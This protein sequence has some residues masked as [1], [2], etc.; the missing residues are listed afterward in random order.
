MPEHLPP[1]LSA[2]W[3]TAIMM[4]RVSAAAVLALAL[5]GCGEPGPTTQQATVSGAVTIDGKPVAM[6]STITFF[7]DSEGANAGGV[8]D[9]IGNYNVKAGD[10]KIGIPIGRYKVSIRPPSPVT[11]TMGAVATDSADYM[12]AMGKP[13]APVRTP[14][15]GGAAGSASPIPE[16]FQSLGST[17]IVI[18][19]Q[20]GPNKL[21]FDLA[22]LAKKK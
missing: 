14:A 15:K 18:E 21:D 7:S 6:D 16:E 20:P 2:T 13:V 12:K 1:V 5:S 19:L 17:P 11:T 9:S 4:S 10:P 22:K 8:I 3:M